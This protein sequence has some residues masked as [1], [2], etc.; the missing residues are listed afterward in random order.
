MMAPEHQAQIKTTVE[1]AAVTLANVASWGLQDSV[2]IA[3][4]ILSVVTSC[5]VIAQLIRFIQKWI[6]EDN[7]F[8]PPK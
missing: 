1:V 8:G 2:A 3:S 6:R 5:W 7:I 4:L